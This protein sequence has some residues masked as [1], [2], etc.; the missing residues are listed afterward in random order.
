MFNEL[1]QKSHLDGVAQ[2][3]GGMDEGTLFSKSHC[4]TG[5]MVQVQFQGLP[6]RSIPCKLKYLLYSQMLLS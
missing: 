4:L 6:C 2:I 1:Y 3:G 5:L